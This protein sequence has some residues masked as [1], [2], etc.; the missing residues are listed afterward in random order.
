[1]AGADQT[2]EVAS[3]GAGLIIR[4]DAEDDAGFQR[5]VR[6]VLDGEYK[7]DV[8]RGENGHF[9]IAPGHHRLKVDNTWNWKTVEFD[10][11]DGDTV[12]YRV[13]NRPGRLTSLLFWMGGGLLYVSIERIR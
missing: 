1:L 8:M 6:V 5:Q 3:S 9:P 2:H 4:R 7:G 12:E 13:V 11:K 10:A